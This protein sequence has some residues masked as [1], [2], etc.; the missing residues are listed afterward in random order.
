MQSCVWLTFNFM[1]RVYY[2]MAGG[3]DFAPVERQAAVVQSQAPEIVAR[4]AT[5]TLLSV[6]SSNIIVQ[7]E[8]SNASVSLAVAQLVALD[9]VEPNVIANIAPVVEA[10]F[11]HEL[12][13]RE[14]AG[15]RVNMRMGQ[16]PDLMLLPSWTAAPSLR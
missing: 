15:S 13:I 5:T 6:P 7:P 4:A 1:G 3:G 11:E 8:V 9:T 2:E 12:D 16:V 14:I 10:I